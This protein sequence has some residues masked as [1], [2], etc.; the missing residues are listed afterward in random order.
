MQATKHKINSSVIFQQAENFPLGARIFWPIKSFARVSRV[1]LVHVRTRNSISS[2]TDAGRKSCERNLT[3]YAETLASTIFDDYNI[4]RPVVSLQLNIPSQLT[5]LKRAR[6]QLKHFIFEVSRTLT[7]NDRNLL[8]VDWY[9]VL[10]LDLKNS[11]TNF[12]DLVT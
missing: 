3:T 11:Y 1:P 5:R 12:L 8:K 4:Y 2:D 10:N 9:F 7:F 6:N